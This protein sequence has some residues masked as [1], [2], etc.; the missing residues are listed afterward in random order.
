MNP[1][2][3]TSLSICAL[4]WGVAAL[5]F[6]YAQFR[7]AQAWDEPDD[8]DDGQDPADAWKPKGWRPPTIK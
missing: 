6:G 7:D 1:L 3:E 8:D 4:C 5:C 2:L